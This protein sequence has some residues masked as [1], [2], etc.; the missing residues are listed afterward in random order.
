[1]IEYRNSFSNASVYFFGSYN[2]L[3]IRLS[4]ELIGVKTDDNG[5]RVDDDV[6]AR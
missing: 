1:V 5:V 2:D 6:C 4:V 3:S